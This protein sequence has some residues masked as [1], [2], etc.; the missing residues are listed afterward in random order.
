MTFVKKILISLSIFMSSLSLSHASDRLEDVEK[1]FQA[2][3][4]CTGKTNKESKIKFSVLAEEIEK[5]EIDK[6]LF[7]SREEFFKKNQEFNSKLFHS[8]TASIVTLSDYIKKFSQ[9]ESLEETYKHAFLYY[10]ESGKKIPLQG[11]TPVPPPPGESPNTLWFGSNKQIYEVTR[12]KICFELNCLWRLFAFWK[13][14]IFPLDTLTS[15]DAIHAH[16]M[17][18]QVSYSFKDKSEF[19]KT[20]LKFIG[21]NP[22]NYALVICDLLSTIKDSLPR[23]I[24]CQVSVSEFSHSRCNEKI[25]KSQEAIQDKAQGFNNLYTN[26]MGISSAI[27]GCLDTIISDPFN[28]SRRPSFRKHLETLSE[29]FLSFRFFAGKKSVQFFDK[30]LD[31]EKLFPPEVEQIRI[32]L[33]SHGSQK[34][35]QSEPS[36]A[37]KSNFSSEKTKNSTKEQDTEKT[38]S[39]SLVSENDSDSEDEEVLY[40]SAY[41]EAQNKIHHLRKQLVSKS[42]ENSCPV[43]SHY[44]RELYTYLKDNIYKYS[45]RNSQKL[46]EE[47]KKLK[48]SVEIN[49]QGKGSMHYVFPT[50]DNPLFGNDKNYAEAYFNVH[51]PHN[52]SDII[53]SAYFNYFQ[54]GFAKVFGLTLDQVSL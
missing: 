39:S 50:E 10:K 12:Q 21:K 42:L 52:K 8:L 23:E 29:D 31:I 1:S 22:E 4:R 9:D 15:Y 19:I 14:A 27:N 25:N 28:V 6:K 18:R 5:L 17:V 11:V 3:I 35:N 53:P 38:L 46:K 16:A 54:S 13:K 40:D 2:A 45:K 48:F 26:F 34:T 30:I 43:L 41:W 51:L 37:P 44:Q 24:Y 47:L 36:I 33:L 49:R 20:L 32:D 7:I